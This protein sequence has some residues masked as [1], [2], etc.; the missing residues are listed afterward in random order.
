[1]VTEQNEWRRQNTK[2]TVENQKKNLTT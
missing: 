2:R 1:M